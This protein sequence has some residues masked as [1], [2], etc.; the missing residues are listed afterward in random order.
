MAKSE[1]DQAYGLM[2]IRS[3]PDN[4][5]MIFPF[6][7]PHE[8]HF[9]MKNTFIPLDMLFVRPDGV[10]GRIA[11]EA[12][13]QDETPISSQGPII[14]VIEIKGGLAKK[15]VLNIGDMVESSAL[16]LTH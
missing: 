1:Q 4:E 15:D 13:P 8:V 12:Q 14:A 3:L 2:F 5:A 16:T 9:W 10:I 6:I 11:A 7:P